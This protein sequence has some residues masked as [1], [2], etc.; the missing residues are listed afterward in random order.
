M[1]RFWTI[2][3]VLL[4][5]P[6][7]AGLALWWRIQPPEPLPEPTTAVTLAPRDGTALNVV[8]RIAAWTDGRLHV[9]TADK[10][11]IRRRSRDRERRNRS[12]G[13]R[14]DQDNVLRGRIGQRHQ[15][16]CR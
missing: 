10:L 6:I 8:G 11:Q 4:G 15:S 1:K 9:A 14:V 7:L 13:R 3:A 2:L 5:L 16:E 12:Q